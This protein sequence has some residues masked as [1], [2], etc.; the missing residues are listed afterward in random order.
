[1][2][3][4][5]SWEPT[6]QLLYVRFSSLLRGGRFRPVIRRHF[7]CVKFDLPAERLLGFPSLLV[8][9]DEISSSNHFFFSP[10]SLASLTHC[11]AEGWPDSPRFSTAAVVL[12]QA[13]VF[14]Q[15]L[16]FPTLA[17]SVLLFTFQSLF[18]CAPAL[19]CPALLFFPPSPAWSRVIC[20]ML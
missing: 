4:F 11:F 3:G 17:P 19:F 18:V 5:T 6:G 12:G 9:I 2:R 8:Q 16:S 1:M 15:F 13:V 20:R 7:S 10:C 14:T